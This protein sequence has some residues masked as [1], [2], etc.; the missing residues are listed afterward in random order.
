MTRESGWAAVLLLTAM[1]AVSYVDRLIL[2][3]IAPLLTD[4]IP[5]SDVELGWLAGS[6]FALLYS[7]ASLPVAQ[8][9]DGHNRKLL[10]VAGVLLWSAMTVGSA[11]THSFAMLLVARSGVA[12]G[13]AVL[14]PAAVSLIADYF[15]R[16]RR[17]LPTTVFTSMAAIM[18]TGSFV[19]GGG[20]L[21]LGQHLSGLT[22]L[23]PWRLTLIIVGLPGIALVTAFGLIVREPPRNGDAA[24][25]QD[26]HGL[27]RDDSVAAFLRYVLQNRSFYVPLLISSAALAFF[28]YGVHTWIATILVRG[29]HLKPAQASLIF[30][31]IVSPLS[32]GAMYF[33]PWFAGRVNMRHSPSGIPVAM[34]A[35]AALLLIVVI[36]APMS[37]STSV[38]IGGM[39]V[40]NMCATA[41]GILPLVA[42]QAIAPS[43]MVG[44]LAAINL[45]ASN[46][47]G[48][49]LGPA[50][51]AYFGERL[52]SEAAAHG[53]LIG[54]DPL[55]CGLAVNGLIAAPV[56]LLCGFLCLRAVQSVNT[57]QDGSARAPA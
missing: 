45:M 28:I 25:G 38:F 17:T 8:W 52:H 13:E 42:F 43:G 32:L 23:A 48:Y 57:A 56:M 15:P 12:I 37:E 29:H 26:R 19:V 18:S 7:V 49:G 14:T 41:W 1:Y 33:W 21:L 34:L 46:L 9:V 6:G 35:A 30:G 31:A 50:L 55:A 4:S 10:L 53:W 11:F 3:I 39:C 36:I 54:A 51:T 22:G 40:A 5:M 24:Q 2:G 44:R 20:A 16:A 47:V 27:Q